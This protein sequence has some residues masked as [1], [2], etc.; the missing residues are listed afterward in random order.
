MQHIQFMR[1]W[2]NRHLDTSLVGIQTDKTFLV[3]ILQYLTKHI[4]TYC[5]TNNPTS[6]NLPWKQCPKIQNYICTRFFIIAK[7][8]KQS[9]YLYMGERVNKLW[10]IHTMKYFAGL[11][12]EWR[13]YLWSYVKWFPGYI[14]KWKKKECLQSQYLTKVFILITQGKQYNFIADKYGRHCLS[15]EDIVEIPSNMVL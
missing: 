8:W 14:F 3:G 5:L 9:K 1:L 12:N 7:R 10:Y 4:S 15:Y 11:K 2:G 13:R 6:K